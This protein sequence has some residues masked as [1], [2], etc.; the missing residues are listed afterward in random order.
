MPQLHIIDAATTR[1]LL[2]YDVCLEAMDKAMRALSDN[3][4]E[5]PVRSFAPIGEDRGV[6]AMMP[7]AAVSSG[8]FGLKVLSLLPENPAKGHPMIQGFIALFSQETGELSAL[9]D[10]TSVTAIRTASASALASATLAKEGATSHG[11]LGTGVQAE[12]HALA[13]ADAV[14]SIAETVIWGRSR[15]KAEALANRLSESF[16]MKAKAGDLPE[17]AACDVVSAVTATTDPIIDLGDI[18]PGAH[19]NLVGSHSPDKREATSALVAGSRLFVDMREAALSEAGDILTPIQ[20]GLITQDHIIGEIGEVRLGQVSGRTA[21][22]EITV[23]KSLGNAA[24]D[25][26]AA[27]AVLETAKAKNLGQVVAS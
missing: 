26:F 14:P 19:I 3:G 20:E 5:A 8:A 11:I 16:G 7:A 24:Q 23:Y 9:V 21:P 22:E 27:V 15:D 18:L 13:I 1:E 12:S 6:L 4:V 2:T 10:G 17:A 25:L